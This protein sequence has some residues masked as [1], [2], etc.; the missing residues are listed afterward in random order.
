MNLNLMPCAFPPERANGTTSQSVQA[1]YHVSI[2]YIVYVS[3]IYYYIVLREDV[4]RGHCFPRGKLN[5]FGSG[6]RED[7]RATRRASADPRVLRQAHRDLLRRRRVHGAVHG[8]DWILRESHRHRSRA[9][10]GVRGT[11]RVDRRTQGQEGK[12]GIEIGVRHRRD[13]VRERRVSG[14]NAFAS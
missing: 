8:E 11:A 9:E 1:T 6:A 2:L 7:H 12:E 4:V 13:S 10:G 5:V 3:R 14:G